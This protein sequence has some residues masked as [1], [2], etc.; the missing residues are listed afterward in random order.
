MNS[1]GVAHAIVLSAWNSS[2]SPAEIFSCIFMML[3]FAK[4]ST[5]KKIHVKRFIYHCYS[6]GGF[7]I[8]DISHTLVAK[9]FPTCFSGEIISLEIS[10]LQ[11]NRHC[12]QEPSFSAKWLIY[13]LFQTWF[14][15]F[16]LCISF[17]FPNTHFVVFFNWQKISIRI[18]S[19]SYSI[20]SICG[21]AIMMLLFVQTNND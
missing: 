7:V 9:L 13:G 14:D 16:H 19:T 6:V 3:S 15:V 18:T 2:Q 17:Y 8:F 21:Y 4:H 10:T 1:F 11:Y 5:K 20:E 12:R